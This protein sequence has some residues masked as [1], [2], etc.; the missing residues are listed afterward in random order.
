MRHIGL[1][2]IASAIAG[3]NAGCDTPSAEAVPMTPDAAPAAEPDRATLMTWNIRHGN[4]SSLEDVADKIR[5]LE[6]DVVALQEVTA[7]EAWAIGYLTDLRVALGTEGKALLTRGEEADHVQVVS[8][9]RGDW[10]RSADVYRWRGDVVVNTHLPVVADVRAEALVDVADLVKAAQVD[11]LLGDLN[12]SWVDAGPLPATRLA[13]VGGLDPTF[14]AEAPEV[15]LDH[16]AVGPGYEVR[17]N[18]TEVDPPVISDHLPVVVD[19]AI[20]P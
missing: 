17:A 19:V 20:S 16:V 12:T 4:L 2:V 1:I 6:V 10:S 3:L 5:G 7:E 14:P 9:P 8:L 15:K 11:V 13:S 18:Y